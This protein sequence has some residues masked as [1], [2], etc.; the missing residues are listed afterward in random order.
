MKYLLRKGK[1]MATGIS[2]V[3][4]LVLLVYGP[5]TTAPPAGHSSEA[6]ATRRG[7]LSQLPSPPGPHVEKIKALSD[8]SWLD[9]GP[10]APDPKW[11]RACGRSWTAKMPLAP[12]LRGAFLF[13]EGVHGY[14]KPNGHYMDDLWLYDINGH[15]WICCYPGA[16]TRT[17]NLTLNADGFEVT[18]DGQPLP[19]ASMVHGYEM[20]TYDSDHHRFMSMPNPGGY[21]KRALPQRQRWWKEPPRDVSPWLFETITGCWNRLRTG[22][23][24]PPSG[25]GDI[26]IYL[27]GR[28]Q[29]FFAH[30][31]SEVWLYDIPGN[32][33]KSV[34]S[35][36]P[37]PPFGID[38][39][40]CYDSKRERIYLGGGSYPV[41]PTDR[42]AFWIYDLK[43]NTFID[44]K[45]HGQPCQGS[46]SYPTK[47]ALMLYDS[48]NDVVLLIVHSFFDS[49]KDRLGIYV[50]DPKTNAWAAK[51]LPVPDRLG[52]NNKPK[53]GFY[54]PVLNAV[55]IHTAGDSQEDGVIWAYRYRRSSVGAK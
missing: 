28:Q 24:A 6:W 53:N 19:V 47:N 36:G 55:F 12:E 3:M 8:Q 21:D 13:G 16:D 38:A 20:T 10:P 44:P 9:L 41:A 17:L 5:G 43:T 51:A 27:P 31:S 30:R 4:L 15:R 2:A 1:S 48:A 54:D 35:R 25:F 40:A 23:P 32:R 34:N 22:T 42:N 29:A 14:T 52:L 45:P 18:T 26:L 33:W 7:A 49:D 39:T 11:G 46:T 37:R 50:Y